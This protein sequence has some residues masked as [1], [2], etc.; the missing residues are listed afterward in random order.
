MKN[1]KI[2]ATVLAAV[3]SI[4]VLSGCGKKDTAGGNTGAVDKD[5]YLNV[6]LG[7]E[8][9]SLD[10]SKSTDLYSSQVLLEVFEGL[11]R[12]EKKDGKDVVTAAGAEKW[13]ISQDGLTW[14][15]HL[16][17]NKWSDGQPVKASDYEY[18]IKRTL[19]PKTASQY[20][21]L[22]M[23]I[24]G[25]AAYNGGKGKVEDVGVK[26]LDEKTLE[27]KL[28]G[29]CPYFLDL[30][31]FKVML[32][33][34][35]D[36][37]EKY[38]D[39][40][41]TEANT[42]IFCGPFTLKTWE[43]NSKM[44]LEKNE[45]YWDKN[46]VKLSKASFKIIKELNSRMQEL[47]NGTLDMAAVA[48]P[49]WIKRFD[50]TKK[51]DVIEGYDGSTVYYFFNQKNKA[52][53]NA[54]IR[55]AL[56]LATNREDISKVLYKNLATPAYAWCPPQVQLGG[57]EF[58]KQ[59]GNPLE[60]AKKN[61]PDL[62][63]LLVQG[64]KE[65]GLGEDPSKLTITYLQSGTDT[66][67]KEFAEYVQQMWNKNLGINVKVEYVEWAVFQKRTDDFDYEVGGMAWSGDYNDP[68]TFFDMWETGANIV[69]TGWSNKDYDALIQSTRGTTDQKARL[70]AFKKAEQLLLVDNAVVAPT[71][72]RM[73]KTYKYQ[74][75]KNA[76]SPVFG[77]GLELKYAYTQGRK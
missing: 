12:V 76:M 6:V 8:P 15:F 25:A 37:V 47:E 52:L 3:M 10:P 21:F 11:T 67:A 4:S 50:D 75:V 53:S 9:K 18:G 63:A 14:T 5:Q 65:A 39:K 44:E 72:Y 57:N 74:Y 13:D 26:A 19:D 16:R 60:E 32:P 71:V 36:I 34:R 2:L 43:H 48:K 24:K 68:M 56:S 61:N 23:P 31:Y 69:S 70:E 41:G 77:S 49:E 73:K 38:G 58:R 28:E 55:L 66:Q 64:M 30:T 33:Q 62:K 46:S 45:N 27:F 51:F 22:L 20:A 7:A 17:D 40:F 1:R 42:L 59:A 29:P 54:K 35:K